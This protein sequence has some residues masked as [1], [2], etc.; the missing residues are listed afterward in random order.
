[1]QY[2]V[3]RP[4]GELANAKF[5]QQG[6]H[7]ETRPVSNSGSIVMRVLEWKDK[8]AGIY[9]IAGVRVSSRRVRTAL[10]VSGT[11]DNSKQDLIE[12][13]HTGDRPKPVNGLLTFPVPLPLS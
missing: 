5:V 8:F 9:P 10:S 12:L 7:S 13:S 6:L 1:M 3:N 2:A 4:E 11:H